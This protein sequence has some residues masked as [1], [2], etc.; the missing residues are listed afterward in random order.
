M[1]FGPTHALASEPRESAYAFGRRLRPGRVRDLVT[2]CVQLERELPVLG[3]AG[4]PANF[5]EEIRPDHVGGA[6]HHLERANGVLEGAL[7]HVAAGVLGPYRLGQPALRFIEHVPLV[8]LYGCHAFAP[9]DLS[10]VV[11]ISIAVPVPISVLSVHV[12]EMREE[13]VD[14]VRKRD[15]VGVEDH[16]VFGARIHH[17]QRFVQRPALVTLAAGAMEDLEP[18][19][20]FPS[21]QDQV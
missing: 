18:G 17:F 16:H 12:V 8:A 7:D 13:S 4:A 20:G 21:I 1:S 2:A 19:L 11:P 6:S 5:T 9:G 14:R 3:E 15:R 10:M